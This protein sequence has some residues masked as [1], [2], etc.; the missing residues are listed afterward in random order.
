MSERLLKLST[1]Q[2]EPDEGAP[3]AERIVSGNP[4]NKTWN[5]EDDG[6]GLYAGI[7]ESTPGE[8]RVEYSEWEFCHILSGLSVLTE[9]DGSVTTL[10]PGDGIV[11]RPGFKG[12]WRVVETT[13]KHYV[14]KT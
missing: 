13:R 4:S 7:W 14:I 6:A 8:R 9:D 3:P 2:A 5:V 12:T 1:D 11:I 10:R